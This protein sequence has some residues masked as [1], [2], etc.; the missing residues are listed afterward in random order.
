MA[1]AG[2]KSFSTGDVLTASDVNTYLMQQTIM[3]FA[4]ATARDAA[5]TSPSEGMNAFLTASDELVYYNGSSWVGWP[6]GDITGITT[7]AA[8]GLSGGATSGTVTLTLNLAGLTA[9]QNFGA[10]GAGVD[11]TF[12][13]G[14]SGDYAMWDASEEKLIIE[15]TNGATALDVTDGNVVIGDGTLTIGSDGAGEDVTFHSDTSGDYMQWDSSAEKLILEGTNGATVLDVTDGNV[16]IGDG[17]LT[18]GADG[19]GEDVT[20]HS[21]TSGDYM[22]WDSSAEKLILEGTNGAT[23]LDITD[24]NVVIADGTLTVGSDGAG[25]DVT[26]HSDTAGD[27]M[28]WDSSAEKLTITGT[29]SQ[30]ALDIADGNVS[31]T[32]GLTVTGTTALSTTG[33]GDATV[34]KAMMK[35]YSETTNAIGATSASQTINLEDG[36]VVT[37]TLS[38]ATTTFTFSNPIASDDCTSFTLILTQDGTGSRAVTWPASVD[39]AGGTAPTLTTTAT[40]GV[41]ILTF[42]TVNAGTTWYGFVAGQAMA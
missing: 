15:G 33:F 16:V 41:D 11:V 7:A 29:D 28:V 2:Y 3:V 18:V 22:Q 31:I 5:I 12:H 40:T 10:D 39:W 6:V 42:L 23:V 19:A 26:F 36:N 37:A 14:T 17:T 1:G 24:G 21:D 27:A 25:E 9:A 35:D 32:D 34:S 4:N 38:V 20:F 8:S 30:T 13:S